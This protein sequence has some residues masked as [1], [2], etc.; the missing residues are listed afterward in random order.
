VL[1]NVLE[2]LEGSKDKAVL[3][4]GQKK[5][6]LTDYDDTVAGILS[7]DRLTLS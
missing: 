4:L 7:K 1:W 5:K 6:H 3:L 2:I